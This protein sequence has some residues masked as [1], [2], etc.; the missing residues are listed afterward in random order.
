M[1]LL[2]ETI[3][4]QLARDAVPRALVVEIGEVETKQVVRESEKTQN[5]SFLLVRLDNLTPIV[6]VPFVKGGWPAD[7]AHR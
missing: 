5:P 2:H 6:F 4:P 7:D 3:S 1:T